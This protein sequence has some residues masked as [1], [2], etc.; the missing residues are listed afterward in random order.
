MSMQVARQQ[1]EYLAG[2]FNKSKMLPGCDI[3]G[4]TPPFEY[5][6]KGSLAYVGRDRAVMDV[7][8]IGPLWGSGPGV[9]WKGFETFSQISHRNQ[10]LVFIDWLRTKLFGRDISRV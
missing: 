8:I 9:V 6:H 5:H 3:D 7:P 2:M 10:L 1:G 4:V